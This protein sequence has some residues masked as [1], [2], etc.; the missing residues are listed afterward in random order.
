V[1]DS[2]QHGGRR[3]TNNQQNDPSPELIKHNIVNMLKGVIG[4]L[5]SNE[6]SQPAGGK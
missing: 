6:G 1:L 5:F 3:S 2:W 4:K